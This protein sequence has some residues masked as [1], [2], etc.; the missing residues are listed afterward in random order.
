MIR[1]VAHLVVAVVLALTSGVSGAGGDAGGDN[2]G[3]ERRARA[4]VRA[5]TPS[6][7]AVARV[8]DS[9]LRRSPALHTTAAHPV[10]GLAIVPDALTDRDEPQPGLCAPRV[11]PSRAPPRG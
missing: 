5:A 11:R 2:A 3:P 10:P 9:G 8:K 4:V 6:S 1:R 7:A